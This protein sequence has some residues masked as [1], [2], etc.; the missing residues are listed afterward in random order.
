MNSCETFSLSSMFQGCPHVTLVEQGCPSVPQQ[1]E[2][3][4]SSLSICVGQSKRNGPQ[5]GQQKK[6]AVLIPWTSKITHSLRCSL[7]GDPNK[8]THTAQ[9]AGDSCCVRIQ[10]IHGK[11]AE[12]TYSQTYTQPQTYSHKRFNYS[13]LSNVSRRNNKPWKQGGPTHTTTLVM[14]RMAL[15]LILHFFV[16][17]GWAR[18]YL[19][20]LSTRMK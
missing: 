18:G 17:Y 7:N 13:Q 14:V 12:L 2:L 4:G 5:L 3:N 6:H 1:L 9:L 11:R 8:T 10:Y 16:C 15:H 20:C 19:D